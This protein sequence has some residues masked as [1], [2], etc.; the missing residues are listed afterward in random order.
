MIE[1]QVKFIPALV[2]KNNDDEVEVKIH[3]FD[4]RTVQV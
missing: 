3:N 4:G 1:D 2:H